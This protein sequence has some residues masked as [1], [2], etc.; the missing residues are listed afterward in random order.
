MTA[1][2]EILAA[3]RASAPA[4]LCRPGP[5]RFRGL[6]YPDLRTQFAKSV[7]A[8]GGT[9][10]FVRGPLEDALAAIPA[11]AAAKKVASV[12]PGALRANVDPRE[13]ADPH[14]LRDVDFC[15][16]A[17]DLGVAENGALFITNH[18]G[19]GRAVAFLAQHLAITVAA[20]ALVHDLHEAYERIVVPRPGFGM[21]VSGPSKTADIEQALV[22]GAH[23]PRSATIF[24][25][26]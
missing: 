17:A 9:C 10:A 13:V 8:V 1:R 16:L 19:A 5:E 2:D 24:L 11:Y 14:D 3:V 20:D 26:G 18:G 6:R 12:V 15:I 4:P 23:G 7:A 21:F 25:I 22:I